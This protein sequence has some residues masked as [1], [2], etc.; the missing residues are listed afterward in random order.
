MSRIAMSNITWDFS[1]R[2]VVVTGSAS[3]IG[4]RAVESFAA[5]GASVYGLDINPP[6]G[7]EAANGARATF[8]ECD[9]T[10]GAAVDAFFGRIDDKHGRLDVLVNNASGFWTQHTIESTPEDDWDRVVALN[11]K[12]TFLCVRRA[13]AL[14]RRSETGR[15]VNLSSLAGQTAGYT[16]SP[17][18]AASKAGVLALTRILAHELAGNGV[19]AN[20]IAPSAVLT[21]RILA[22]RDEEDRARTT[23]SIPLGRYGDV[24]EIVNWMMFLASAESGYMTGQTVSVNGGRFM[25]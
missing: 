20:A 7:D 21:D 3:G 5:A 25:A 6:E 18:Y 11:L 13:I 23:A 24:N 12:G 16:T 9:I 15:V 14:L 17:A 8:A 19:T 2:V 22:V 4:A 10:D 1:D